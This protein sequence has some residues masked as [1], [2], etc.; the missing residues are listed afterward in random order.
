MT[1]LFAIILVTVLLFIWGKYPPDMV[2][3]GSLLALY[4]T[5]ILTVPE[6]LSGFSNAT[7]V[8]IAALFIIGEGLSRTGWTAVIGRK[9]VKMAK[10]KISRLIVLVTSGSGTLS[11]F[12][13]NTGTVAALLPVTIA[14]AW[15]AGTLP[16]KLLL[17]VAF[18]SNAGGLLT[19]TGSPTNI[20]VSD[21]LS[22]QH[23]VGFSFFEFSLI[24]VPVLLLAVLYMRVFA[25]RLLPDVKTNNRPVNLDEEVHKWISDFSIGENLYRLRVRSMSPMLNTPLNQWNLE[26]EYGVSVVRLRRR[27]PKPLQGVEAY[28]EFP[29]GET[30]MFYHDILT[31]KGASKDIERLTREFKLG[32]IPQEFQKEELKKEFINQEVGLVEVIIT[33]K[34][35]FVGRSFPLGQYLSGFGIQLL[36][37]NRNGKPL[38]DV[39][40]TLKEG[41][42]LIIRGSWEN[43]DKLKSIYENLV[44]CGSPESMSK[45]VDVLNARSYMALGILV[46]MIVLL[47]FKLVPGVIGVMICAALM[48]LTGCVPL[49]KVYKSIGWESV[50]MIGAMIPLGVALQK[51]GAAELISET[52]VSAMGNS[53]PLFLMAGLFLLTTMLSQTINNSATAVL[54]AP[55]AF[56][57]ATGIGVSPRPFMMAVAVSASTAYITPMGT[58]TN[59]MVMGAGGY[60]FTD[61]VKVG[62]PLLLLTFILTMVLIPI[63][64]P[65]DT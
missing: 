47:A 23:Q 45:D 3:L 60:K 30:V 58:T 63:I 4:L 7:V 21:Y 10:N 37:I 26:K 22:D 15:G 53:N 43:I 12:V 13:S 19:L 14:A 35:Y 44:I 41:D 34:S 2:A 28:V 5:G 32:L 38:Q 17:P 48:L 36:G 61:Y 55:I 39:N 51:T 49:G 1:L 56:M 6:A 25:V 27:H 18:G 57:A 62:T 31:V 33:P 65:F 20:I 11:G 9:F 40:V 46:L 59:A 29:E 64:W 52:M 54:M 16:S 24:G 50:I 8:M 42:S